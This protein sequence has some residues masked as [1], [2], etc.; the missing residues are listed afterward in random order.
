MGEFHDWGVD[1][2]KGETNFSQRAISVE[3]ILNDTAQAYEDEVEL[4]I[5]NENEVKVE[6]ESEVKVE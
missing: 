2:I 4:K 3:K 6:V 1:K 5:E